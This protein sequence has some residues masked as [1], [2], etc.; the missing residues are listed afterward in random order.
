MPQ[1]VGYCNIIQIKRVVMSTIQV[2]KNWEPS[3]ETNKVK[4]NPIHREKLLIDQ[5][6]RNRFSAEEMMGL[7]WV[8][9]DELEFMTYKKDQNFEP[10]STFC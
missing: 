7:S 6:K 10:K 8:L 9:F 3:I 5:I 1:V 2:S 4:T